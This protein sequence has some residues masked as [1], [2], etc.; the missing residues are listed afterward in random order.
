MLCYGTSFNSYAL[1]N[2]SL[3]EERITD[4]HLQRIN[5]SFPILSFQFLTFRQHFHISKTRLLNGAL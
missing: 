1:Q 4:E 2:A 5:Y 3:R